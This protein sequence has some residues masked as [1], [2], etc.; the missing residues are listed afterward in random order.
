MP[1]SPVFHSWSWFRS[2]RAHI[3]RTSWLLLAVVTTIAAQAQPF[4][5]PAKPS[6]APL[7]SATYPND[8][9]GDHIEDALSQRAAQARTRRQ[10]ATPTERAAAE[11]ALAGMVDVELIFRDQITQEQ[12]DAF[13]NAGGTIDYIY[14]AVSY[15]W[16]GRIPLGQVPVVANAMSNALVLIQEPKA[17]RLHL[18]TAT[19]TGRVRPIWA[20]GFAGV[21]S[22]FQGSPNITIATCD[23]GADESHADLAGRRVYWH[24]FSTDAAPNPVDLIQHGSHVMGIAT[25]T[26]LSSGNG[27]STLQFTDEYTLNGVPNGSFY[28]NPLE[29][30]ATPVTVTFTARWNG[31]GGGGSTTLHLLYHT[32]GVNGGYT[33]Q[34]SVTGTS[35]LTLTTTFTPTTSRVYSPGLISNGHMTDYVT[36]CQIAGYPAVGDGFNTM[37]GVAP[38]C[39]WACAKVF[40]SAGSG[41]LS[42]TDAAIDD[43]VANRVVNNIK[44]MNLSLGANGSPGIDTTTRQKINSAVN[45]GI[46]AVISA[47]NDGGTQQVDDPG[48]A[49]M[50][51]TIGAANDVNQLTDYTSEGFSSPTSTPGQEEDYKPDIIAPGGSANYYSAILSVDS[52]SGDGPAFSDQQSND[53]YNIQGT[54][55]ASPFAAGCAALVIDALQKNGVTWN[56]NSSLH[57]RLVKMVLCATATESNIGRE[58]NA[59]NPTLERAANGPNGF[60]VGKDQYE[61][62]GMINPDAAVEAVSL[63]FTNG[64]TATNSLGA[65]AFDRRAWARKVTLVAGQP[66][67]PTLTVPVTGDFDLYLYSSNSSAYGTPLMLASSTTAATGASETF[68]YTSSS[69][70]NAILVVKWVSGSGPFNLS[71]PS[72]GVVANFI[73]NT[74]NGFAPLTVNFTNLSTGATNYA[75]DFGDGHSSNATNAINTY[76]SAGTYSVTLTAVGLSGTNVLI[77]TNYI[78]VTNASPPV[79]GFSATPTNGLA[80]LTV[81]FT[82]SSTGASSYAWDFGDGKTSSATNPSNTFTNSGAFTVSLTAIGPGGT[83]LLVRSAYIVATNYPPPVA[84]FVAAPTNGVAPL[85]VSFTNLSANASSYLW[86]FGDGKISTITNTSNTYTNPGTYTVT[87]RATGLGGTNMLTRTNYI[88]VTNPPPVASFAATPTNGLAPLSVQFTNSS[89]GASSY[90][91]DFGDGKTSTAANPSNTYTNAGSFTVSL[92]AVGLGGTNILVR[93]NY[94][95]A[96]NYPPPVANFAASP[97]NGLAPLSVSFT[98]LSANASSYNWNFGDGNSSTAT[99]AS[100]IYTN[101]GTYTVTL[102]ATGFGGT[103]ALT[104]TNYILVTNAPQPVAS[105]AATPT[106]GLAPLAVQFTNLS[107]GA[108]SYA[109]DFGD[110]RT[111]TAMNPSNTY[112][113]AG[114]FTVSLTAMGPGGTNLLVRNNYIVATNYPPPSANFVASPTNGVAPL[115]VSFTNL[116]AN[117][118]S[119]VWDFGDGNSSTATNASNIYTSSGTYSVTLTA[120]GLGG[121]NALTRTNYILVLY[122]PPVAD[123]AAQPTNGIAPLNVSFTNLSANASSYNW[124]FGDGNS[125][126]ATNASNTYTNPGTYSVTLT[127]A[128]L[129][130]TNALTRTNYILVLYPP[131]VADFAGEPTNGVAPLSV[132]FTNFSANASSYLWDFGDGNSSTSTNASNTYTNPGTYTVTLAAAGLGGTN[133]LTLTNYIIVLCP[134]PVPDFAGQPTNGIAPLSVSF[135][136]LSANASS[137]T[138]DFGDGNSSTATNASN[139]YTNPGTYTVTLTATGLGGTN[140]LTLTNY[141]LV[142]YPTPVADFAAEPTNGVAPLSV[143]FTNLSANASSYLWDFGDGNNST[144]VNPSN[145]YTN[146]GSFTVTLTALGAGGTNSIVRT[147]YILVTEPPRLVVAPVTL[148]F[149]IVLTGLTSQAA[150]VI[151][152]AGGATLVGTSTVPIGPFQLLDSSNAVSTLPFAVAPASSTNIFLQ[153][154]PLTSGTLSNLV[155][156]ISNG[157]NSTNPVLGEGMTV[158]LILLPTLAGNSFFFSFETVSGKMYDIQFKDSLDDPLWQTLITYPGAGTVLFHT[159]DA[160]SSPQRFYRLQVH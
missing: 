10:S 12:I 3:S 129:G 122:P 70:Q 83:N 1:N 73:G 15:G 146:G 90:A 95:V 153:F 43:L 135:T 62:Y 17:A 36:T 127:A 113:N 11:A 49:A 139:I 46:V 65:S 130:G 51:L 32:R 128:G 25:G 64:T 28:P 56:F 142:L 114:T 60:P 6:V 42:W 61:G 117:A 151:S 40:T 88:L 2:A 111:S 7:I 89:T 138:W 39:N 101:A 112:S 34:A 37:R 124:N 50:A 92:T 87:L 19:R 104:R 76:L 134:A 125:S 74:T 109:W 110:G 98:N 86:T 160:T 13:V 26:G 155:T 27:S 159:N 152:N 97:T 14:R 131:P 8:A 71:T 75:W 91:W 157:G 38:G 5:P 22:G 143:S 99:N 94:I 121:T 63:I 30:P 29:L 156:F 158:P 132:S 33:A 72:G 79:A 82:N 45:N 35:P 21:A 136:N 93:N 52:N 96:T 120:A 84:N 41:V 31:S 44:V 147:N 133:A 126:T 9:D 100:N 145:L 54:S 108:N 48:R 69:N 53:Y 68:S 107:K 106:N 66:F 18:D 47:G 85:S 141:I 150:F 4:R 80:P 119:Y 144:N 81:Q 59:N 58:G 77:R 149:G 23:T 137:Y 55:M 116:S 123:F 140:A 24:D 20:P 102:T 115:S 105:F 148:D 57:S 118:S 154:S 67:N 16:N 103:N 78:L